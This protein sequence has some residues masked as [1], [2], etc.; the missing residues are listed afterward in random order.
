MILSSADIL[1]ILGSSEIVR[2]SAKLKVVDGKPALSGAE[3]L[4]IY[5]DRFPKVDEFEATWTIYIESDGSE[6][7]DLVLAEIKK[8]LPSVKIQDG[9]LTTITTTDFLSESTQRA[10]EAPKQVQAK[11]DLTQYEDRF[12]A[13]VEDVQDQ[14]LL[15]NSGRPGK[16]GKDGADGRDGKDGKDV[17]ATDAELFD[18]KDVDQSVLPM[19]KGQVLTWDG[20]K[21]TNLYVR[22]VTSI[23]GGGGSGNEPD[24]GLGG[25]VNSFWRFNDKESESY[26]D[27]KFRV[28]SHQSKSDWSLTTEVYIAYEDR[29][30]RDVKNYL[31]NLIKPGQYLYIQ[32]K[33]RQ[34]AYALFLVEAEPVDAD[35]KGARIGVSFVNQGSD[36]KSI[37]S[38]KTCALT[39]ALVSGEIGGGGGIADAPSDSQAYVRR[40][41]AWVPTT[42]S[43]VEYNLSQNSIEDLG[44]VN[45]A[46]MGA[47][48]RGEALIWDGTTWSNGGDLTG[49]SF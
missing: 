30:G 11:V 28:N 3:G 7:D 25:I 38:D 44:N 6:P 15:I 49:G 27:G 21:W 10:P 8:L 26:S 22:Q 23:S 1:R 34:D 24:D 16:D 41:A 32:R 33:D 13:L 5:I 37:T 36:I 39:F 47:G 42:T 14:M 29:D 9:L 12:Q 4:L 40:N 35:P 17:V 18:L 2:L 46:V 48:Q 31:L 43:S 19:E 20:T 45:T